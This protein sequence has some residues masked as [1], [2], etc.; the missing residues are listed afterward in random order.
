MTGKLESHLIDCLYCGSG[1]AIITH[2]HQCKCTDTTA[3]TWRNRANVL[4]Q[5]NATIIESI[6]AW[7]E[8]QTIR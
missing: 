8:W 5:R 6:N 2:Y 4:P 3:N 1:K 7:P